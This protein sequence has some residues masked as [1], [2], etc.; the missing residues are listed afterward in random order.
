M[1]LRLVVAYDGT[2]FSGFATSPGF[3]TV[4]GEITNALERISGDSVALTCAG[5]TD[6]GVHASGQ[7]VTV[8]VEAPSLSAGDLG[9]RIDRMVGPEVSILSA[10]EVGS[11]FDARRSARMRR[12]RYTI[13]NRAAG[14]PLLRRT[15]W[16][17]RSPVLDLEA[18]TEAAR[19]L[20]GTHDF[21]SFCRR[22]VVRTD[23]GGRRELDR[24]RE[25]LETAWIDLGD[26]L[27]RFDVGARSF[28][29]QMVRSVVGS[30]VTV[31]SGTQPPEWFV[32]LLAARD[33]NTAGPV[34]P[35]QGLCLWEVV[36]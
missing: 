9:H 14:D 29:Q 18:M 26:D 33:R 30:L 31:G 2:D 4:A 32:E 10:D 17:V 34:A 6:A 7:V 36:Y 35:P 8:D 21:S 23:G 22:I 15:T 28:C 20:V 5:R 1:R 11:D 24:T 13:L 3:R 19:A 27:I 12:Y 16:H 25:V